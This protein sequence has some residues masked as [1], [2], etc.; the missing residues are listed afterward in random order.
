MAADALTP[1]LNL[2]DLPEHV[3]EGFR[4]LCEHSAASPGQSVPIPLELMA[5]WRKATAHLDAALYDQLMEIRRRERR[6]W[7]AAAEALSKVAFGAAGVVAEQGVDQAEEIA[8]DA[9]ADV[10]LEAAGFAA[11]VLL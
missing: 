8:L 5:E 9:C 1:E 3:K 2:V 11:N 10:A 6:G 4:R 7:G